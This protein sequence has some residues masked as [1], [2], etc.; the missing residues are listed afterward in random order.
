MYLSMNVS[1]K[2]PGSHLSNH[3]QIR[4]YI[5]VNGNV[6]VFFIVCVENKFNF[7]ASLVNMR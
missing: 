3:L 2:E 5:V 6:A 4:K 1:N 7:M